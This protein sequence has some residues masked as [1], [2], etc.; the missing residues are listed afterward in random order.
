MPVPAIEQLMVGG[1]TRKMARDE[2][3]LAQDARADRLF[4]VISGTVAVR[5]T[6]GG[7]SRELMDYNTGE[8]AGLLALV[9]QRPAPYELRAAAPGEIIAVDANRLARLRAAFHP[10]GMAV[11]DAFTPMLVEHL[12]QLDERVVRLAQ[13]KNVSVSGSGQTFRRDDR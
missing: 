13:R 12:R 3:L 6:R 5:V 2:L 11:L 9:D 8:V 1:V 10:V 4:I 7:V